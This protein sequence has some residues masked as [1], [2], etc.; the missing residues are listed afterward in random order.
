MSYFTPAANS[1]VNNRRGHSQ[2]PSHYTSFS[3]PSSGG[4]YP[5]PPPSTTRGGYIPPPDGAMQSS[6]Q[7]V[8]VCPR[9]REIL[10]PGLQLA[11]HYIGCGAA[12]LL[13]QTFTPFDYPS[14]PRHTGGQLQPPNFQHPPSNYNGRSG[15][16]R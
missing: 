3:L 7:T 10:P 1:N 14:R 15:S 11:T 8:L 2:A 13:T 9:C 12:A 4:G 5:Q 6:G 16:R